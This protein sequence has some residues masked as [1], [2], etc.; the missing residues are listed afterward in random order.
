[1]CYLPINWLLLKP[2]HRLLVWQQLLARLIT[3]Y[4]EDGSIEWS[5]DLTDC[6]IAMDRI[7][8]FND[9]VRNARENLEN[10]IK[11]I[12]LERDLSFIDNLVQP[13]R[14]RVNYRNP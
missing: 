10:Y 11:L 2:L 4:L 1:M 3:F 8:A 12:E 9:E 5:A 6:R 14:V 7:S 13:N